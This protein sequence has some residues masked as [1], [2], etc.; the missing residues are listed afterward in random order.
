[1]AMLAAVVVG[2]HGC[3]VYEEAGGFVDPAA[4]DHVQSVFVALDDV[5]G[6]D[7]EEIC[8]AAFD[9]GDVEV[10]VGVIIVVG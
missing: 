5:V 2:A 3:D 1:M 8:A 9:A 10:V 6:V 4:V 7:F